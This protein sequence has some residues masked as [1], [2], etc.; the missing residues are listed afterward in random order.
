[1]L[2]EEP[3]EG[4]NDAQKERVRRDKIR[5][6]SVSL[7]SMAGDK[8]GYDSPVKNISRIAT[9]SATRGIDS[10]E[11]AWK[12]LKHDNLV[13]KAKTQICRRSNAA[14]GN[15]IA[16]FG[17]YANTNKWRSQESK[18]E[19]TERSRYENEDKRWGKDGNSYPSS[20]GRSV[21]EHMSESGDDVDGEA[22]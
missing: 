9:K 3:T 7:V 18:S 11:D 17:L 13:K 1:M 19:G 22:D 2:L 4:E 6:C 15:E 20:G 14:Y 8:W 12:V 21:S 5:E 10:A 16:S